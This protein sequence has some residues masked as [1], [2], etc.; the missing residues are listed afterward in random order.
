MTTHRMSPVDAAWYH[1]DGPANLAM[2]TGIMLTKERLDFKKVRAVYRRRWV[3]FD[4]FRQR[5]VERGFPLPIPQ[6]EDM[7]NFDIDQHVHQIALPAPHDRAALTALINDIASTPLDHEQPLWQVHVIDNVDGRQRADHALPPLHRR[8]HGNAGG[9]RAALRHVAGC[10]LAHRTGKCCQ[11]RARAG[12]PQADTSLRCHRERRQESA[13]C[14][15]LHGRCRRPSATNDR[16]DR[17]G[18]RRRGN[19]GGGASESVRSAITPQGRIRLEKARC[20][21][22]TDRDRRHQGHRRPVGRESE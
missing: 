14:C 20:V 15:Q 16:Q 9:D 5:V 22:E 13:R 8:R 18:S 11:D 2:V 21:V 1:M 3:G 7:P 4:R 17:R 6:W 12:R 19:A 10:V